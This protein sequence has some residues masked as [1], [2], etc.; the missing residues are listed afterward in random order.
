MLPQPFIES[1]RLSMGTECADSII[2]AL[3]TEPP[4]SIRINPAKIGN[5][6]LELELP[7]DADALSPLS[8]YGYFLNSRPSF[9][10]DPMLHAGAYYVQES[11]SMSLEVVSTLLGSFG[12]PLKVLDLC[13]APGGKSTHLIS[14]LRD[15]PHSFIVSNEV[16]HSRATILAE[17][18]A[19]W[20]SSN[21][22]VTNNDPAD[23]SSLTGYF[24]IIAVDA[25]CSGE[26]MFRKDLKARDEWSEENVDICAARQRRIISDIWPSLKEGGL[27]L[28][29]TCT[30]NKKENDENVEWMINEFHAEA[31]VVQRFFPGNKGCGE[32]FF[33]ALLRKGNGDDFIPGIKKSGKI[34]LKSLR[35]EPYKKK[36]PYVK[37]GFNLFTKGELL[38]GY[39]ANVCDEM[40]FVESRLRCIQSGVAVA[41][42]KGDSLVPEADLALSDAIAPK[43][44]TEVEL[45]KEE[46]LKFLSKEPIILPGG[47]PKGYV[48]VKYRSLPLGFLK[49]I[50]NRTNNLWPVNWRIRM[51]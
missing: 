48:L 33:L 22:V 12:R 35:M 34:D 28:Y 51:S 5:P 25:P 18:I 17:N 6:L 47:T 16:I 9:T 23:F 32:G 7:F 11:S 45:S 3:D 13:A 41:A 49:N 42:L 31:L 2:A 50:G 19:K 27:V 21:V 36:C 43:A 26:G 20:G 30:F 46:A 24:D 10:L 29:S 37:E 4:V 39:P 38:K 44:F 8:R 14:L 40:L 15:I 1:L